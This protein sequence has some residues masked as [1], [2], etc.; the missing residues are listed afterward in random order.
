VNANIL[1]AQ[2]HELNKLWH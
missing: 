1:K 2:K